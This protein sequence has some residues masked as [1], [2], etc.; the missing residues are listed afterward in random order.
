MMETGPEHDAA[1]PFLT[2][3]IALTTH[4]NTP[5]RG[6]PTVKGCMAVLLLEKLETT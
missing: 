6:L 5:K 1:P 4:T 3:G 2:L